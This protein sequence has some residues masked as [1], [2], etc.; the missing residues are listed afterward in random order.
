MVGRG[1]QGHGQF[2]YDFRLEEHVSSDPLVHRIDAVLD[3]S[4]VHRELAPY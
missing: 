3:T 4:W 1:E 2:L